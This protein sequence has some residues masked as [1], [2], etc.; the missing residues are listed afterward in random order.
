M[1]LHLLNLQVL[2]CGDKAINVPFY[3]FEVVS[4]L[5]RQSLNSGA[6]ALQARNADFGSALLCAASTSA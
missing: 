6:S 3:L 4:R 1:N 2:K 5:K